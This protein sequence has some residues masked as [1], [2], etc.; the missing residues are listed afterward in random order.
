MEHPEKFVDPD[1]LSMHKR[2]C[3]DV[4]ERNPNFIWKGPPYDLLFHTKKGDESFS[5]IYSFRD[6]FGDPHNFGFKIIRPM[7]NYKIKQG[8]TPE[9]GEVTFDIDLSKKGGLDSVISGG[10]KVSRE[11]VTPC[12][13]FCEFNYRDITS[14]ETVINEVARLMELIP[15]IDDIITKL[16]INSRLIGSE[17]IEQDSEYLLGKLAASNNLG[18]NKF[19][20]LSEYLANSKTRIKD[21]KKD[22]DDNMKEKLLSRVYDNY[23]WAIDNL[24]LPSFEGSKDPFELVMYDSPKKRKEKK[25][26]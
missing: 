2:I 5:Y 24:D 6:Y 10:F 18:L 22:I 20:N 15:T 9:S 16:K 25:D 1:R 23:N 4:N 8:S 7:R 17:N 13:L 14:T 3:Y 26:D 21:Y 12:G 11:L 19:K